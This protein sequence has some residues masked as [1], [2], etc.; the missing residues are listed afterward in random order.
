M[1]LRLPAA[2]AL[3]TLLLLGLGVV[4]CCDLIE[5]RETVVH[6]DPLDEVRHALRAGLRPSGRVAL[7]SA[8][9]IDETFRPAHHPR[10]PP[11]A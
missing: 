7:A 6:G 2:L 1:R 8:S 4:G 11:V 9:A 5:E 3:V 10:A